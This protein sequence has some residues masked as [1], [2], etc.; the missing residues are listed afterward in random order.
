MPAE[1]FLGARGRACAKRARWRIATVGRVTPPSTRSPT[2]ARTT[3]RAGREDWA[4]WRSAWGTQRAEGV[5][6]KEGRVKLLAA[7]PRFTLAAAGF[8]MMRAGIRWRSRFLLNYAMTGSMTI[9]C[10][11]AEISE[12]TY[13]FHLR[14]DPAFAQLCEEAKAHAID[15]LHTRCF[16]R[17]LEGDIEPVHWQGVCVD[18]VRKFPERLQIEML[19]AHLPATFKTPGSAPVTVNTGDNI[20]VM[21]EPTRLR[22]IEKRRIALEAMPD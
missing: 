15:L 10:R 12:H 18:Y 4:Q 11:K 14:N 16:Q 7:T 5:G 17:A 2:H 19:R 6:A 3:A 22:L 1:H 8:L 20:L 9:G 21:D 13:Y